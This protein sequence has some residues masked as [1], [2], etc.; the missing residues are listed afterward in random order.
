MTSGFSAIC[1][2]A[3]EAACV[4]IAE[5]ENPARLLE[6]ITSTSVSHHAFQTF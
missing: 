3:Q 5:I 4:P 2:S 6:K 1:W